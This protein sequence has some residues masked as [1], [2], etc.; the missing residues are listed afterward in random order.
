MELL[1]LPLCTALY[2]FISVVITAFKG[3]LVTLLYATKVDI[4]PAEAVT[5]VGVSLTTLFFTM[6]MFS[7][8]AQFRM[9]R[10]EDAIR[11]GMRFVVAKVIIENTSGITKGIY[12][13]F[14][15]VTGSTIDTACDSIANAVSEVTIGSNS[16]GF[17]GTAYLLLFLFAAGI[18]CIFI[19]MFVKIAINFIGIAFEIGIHQALAPIAL[20]TLC[21]DMTR[22]TGIAFIKSYAASCLQ[23]AVMAA[24]FKV[25][26]DLMV[27]LS[28]L[29]LL[30][31]MGEASIDL[32]IFSSV[33]SFITPLICTIALSKAVKL[34][35]DMT[36]RMFGA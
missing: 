24:I 17:L 28:N 34:A 8:V 7:Q 36:K 6:E 15:I 12:G 25:Y 20:S 18:A 2:A 13:M 19:V 3:Y 30:K 5:S 21:N 33:V 35:S 27:Q 9:E 16:G 11:L 10:I 32:G 14:R 4:V 23:I 1:F 22:P 26:A 29:N 31:A